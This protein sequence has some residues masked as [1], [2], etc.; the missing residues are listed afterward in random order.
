MDEGEAEEAHDY[1][2]GGVGD[3]VAESVPLT[4]LLKHQDEAK[5]AREEHDVLEK[6]EV[7]K[8]DHGFNQ[9]GSSNDVRSLLH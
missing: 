3:Q 8:A 6:R 7:E 5:S 4:V 2:A 9:V 1:H